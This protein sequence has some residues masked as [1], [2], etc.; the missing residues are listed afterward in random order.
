MYL[1]SNFF[2]CFGIKKCWQSLRNLFKPTVLRKVGLVSTEWPEIFHES[3]QRNLKNPQKW[4]KIVQKSPF[5][6][7]NLISKIPE[8]LNKLNLKIPHGGSKIPETSYFIPHLDT[9]LEDLP[10]FYL[11]IMCSYSNL[12]TI[13]KQRQLFSVNLQG[14]LTRS[15]YECSFKFELNNA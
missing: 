13:S 3:N 10:L 14:D 8:T 11:S 6:Y 2:Q 7:E 15:N 4:L 12:G 1:T 5:Y 9:L